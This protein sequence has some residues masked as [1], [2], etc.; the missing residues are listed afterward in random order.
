V[1]VRDY[2]AVLVRDFHAVL[3]RDFHAVFDLLYVLFHECNV[4]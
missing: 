2:H 3:V 4:S 1:I